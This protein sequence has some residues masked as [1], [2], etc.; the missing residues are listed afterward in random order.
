MKTPR[1]W[2]NKN[3]VAFLLLPL[4]ILY[5]FIYKLR[6]F[7][8]FN[9]YNSKIPAIC[10]G[11]I[12]AGGAGKTPTAIEIAKML[13]KNNKTFCFL[14]KGYGGRFDGVVKLDNNSITE[15]VGDEPL[16]LFEFGDVFVSKNR[17]DGLKYINSNYDYDYIIIDDGLQNPTFVK[18]KIVLVIDGNF[19]F[20]NGFILPAGALRDKFKNIHKKVD[21]VVLNNGNNKYIQNLCDKYNIKIIQSKIIADNI[22]DFKNKEYVAFCGLG[23][24][25]KFKNTLLENNIKLKD[26]VVFEDHYKYTDVDIEKLENIGINLITTKKD[27]IKLSKK[28]KEKVKYLDV[29][30]ELD[31]SELKMVLL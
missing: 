11:N 17:V 7:V 5:Y 13:K 18:D 30:I 20:G 21:V 24:P 2:N 22:N 23:R 6:C 3:I 19:G 14:S 12:V 9:P 1:F 25:E 27:W 10:I 8:N 26:F 31:D 4:S 15:V 29:H 16:L 28:Y